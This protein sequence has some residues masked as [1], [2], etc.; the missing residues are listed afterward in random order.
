MDLTEDELVRAIRKVLSGDAPG[1]VVAVGDDAAVVEPGRH[2]GVLT[3]D[4]L[5]ENVHFRRGRGSPTDL[6]YKAVVVN[7]SDVAAMGGSPRY[8]VTCV[9]LPPSV[10]APWVVELY[11]GMRQAAEDH[12]MSVIGG[13]TNRAGGV[14]IA[15][16]VYGE[17]AR[18]SA[19]TRAG[20]RVG[21]RVVVTGRLGAAAG[22]L[23]LLE[24]DP[25]DVKDALGTPWERDLAEAHQ[26]PTARVGEG[27]MLAQA[28]ATAMI[29][30]SDGLAIDL[31]RLCAESG[32]G[33]RIR[34]DDVP[35]AA[36]LGELAAVTG[37]DPLQMALYGGEDYELL[38]TL[39]PEAVAALGERMPLQYGTSL[40]DIGEV[41][42]EGL[43]AVDADGRE[44]ALEPRGW[45]HFGG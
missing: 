28:G 10:E 30:I 36:A 39:A 40:T 34:V 15:V 13:D 11:G 9:A 38:A 45:D 25:Q 23:R 5:I 41:T 17:V 32:V 21:D 26:R 44:S 24:A 14:V 18:G 42:E 31:S 27:Q 3:A 1:V 33:A 37:D 20:A 7:V 29:D 22:G 43:F 19:V 35:V 4:M 6:G 8:A 12:G 2:D 16:T